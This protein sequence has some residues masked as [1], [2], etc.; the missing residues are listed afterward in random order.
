M[1]YEEKLS[2]IKAIPDDKIISVEGVPVKNYLQEAENLFNW[3]QADKEKLTASGLQWSMVEDLPARIDTLREAQAR[4]VTSD[5]GDI[6]TE[7]EWDEKLPSAHRFRKDLVRTLKFM[8]RGSP[9][10]VS[11]VN[12]LGEGASIVTMIQSLRDISVLGRDHI[13]ELRAKNF[14]VTLLDRAAE[15]SREIAA[16]LGAVTSRRAYCSDTL[17]IRNQAYTYLRE[18]VLEVRSH[19]HYLFWNDVAKLKGYS[20]EFNRKRYAKTK[21]QK[22]QNEDVEL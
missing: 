17:K 16:L 7:K 12:K 9:D 10:L 21:N 20:S 3:C 5:T 18:V 6:I 4:W 22:K 14:D 11:K 15:M 2:I 13:D 19:G 1:P 8:F